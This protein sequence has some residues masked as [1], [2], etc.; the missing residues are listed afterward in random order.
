VS[1]TPH[2]ASELE[3][4]TAVPGYAAYVES[5]LERERR[6]SKYRYVRR[7]AWLLLLVPAGEA[8]AWRPTAETHSTTTTTHTDATPPIDRQASDHTGAAILLGI[9][10]LCWFW[11]CFLRKR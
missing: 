7:A 3:K 1:V 11:V 9:L 4:L 10:L 8:V 2:I 5:R 6:V